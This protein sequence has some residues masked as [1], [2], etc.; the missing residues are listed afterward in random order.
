MFGSVSPFVFFIMSFANISGE[1]V[2]PAS[3]CNLVFAPGINQVDIDVVPKGVGS[4][5]ITRTS[6]LFSL[7]A[8]AAHKPQPPAPITMTGIE[9]SN[10]L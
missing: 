10:C 3:L 2:I 6:V 1:S 7:T 9:Y 5:S 8:R 4:L